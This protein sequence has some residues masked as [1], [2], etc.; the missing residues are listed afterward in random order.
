MKGIETK[1]K[2]CY[3]LEPVVFSDERGYFF[4]SYQVDKLEAILGFKP[5]FVQDNE[6]ESRYGV[7]RGLHMQSGAYAQAK[8]VRVIA[9]SVVD[10]AVDVRPN[11]PTYGEYIA[12]ELSAENKKQLFIPKGF[13]HG[14]S[15]LS[16][17]AVFF[18]KCDNGYHKESE[19]GVHPLDSHLAIDW[20]IP[21][22][23]MLLSVKD[24][25][26][27]SLAAFTAKQ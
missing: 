10:I 11:S 22:D 15:V 12:V 2:G 13:L 25:T 18:Y 17:T 16:E 27:Q 21:L 9:G 5:D 7:V 26:A 6:S 1:L 20:Q 8:L 3:I 24:K 14:F 19:A 23:K 4:E